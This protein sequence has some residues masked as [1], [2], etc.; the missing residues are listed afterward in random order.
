MKLIDLDEHEIDRGSVFRLR[1]EYPYE[2]IVVFMLVETGDEERPLGFMVC[3]G[4]SAG[5]TFVRLPREAL[6]PG[7]IMLSTQWLISNWEHWVYSPIK[8]SEVTYIGHYD[9][10]IS[11]TKT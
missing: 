6:V 8:V 4:Y 11:L 1:G 9:P 3:T 2:E 5:H 10:P 7:T